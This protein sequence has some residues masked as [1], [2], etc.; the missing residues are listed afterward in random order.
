MFIHLSGSFSAFAFYSYV[1]EDVCNTLYGGIPGAQF[2]TGLGQWII[3]C[4]VEIDIALQIEYGT[5]FSLVLSP[6]DM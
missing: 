1:S 2:D 6:D 3:P 5:L 4:D